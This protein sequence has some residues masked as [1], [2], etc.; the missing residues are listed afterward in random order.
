MVDQVIQTVT[1]IGSQV[2]IGEWH[3][4]IATVERPFVPLPAGEHIR[5]DRDVAVLGELGAEIQ[6][7]LDEAVPL[8]AQDD[9]AERGGPLLRDRKKRIHPV[10]EVH[11]SS[12]C[13]RV[14]SLGHLVLLSVG[15]GLAA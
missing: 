14:S 2:R 15:V 3:R 8:V 10:A 6:G 1:H 5:R 11:H 12:N 7:V 13:A 9:G 4:N